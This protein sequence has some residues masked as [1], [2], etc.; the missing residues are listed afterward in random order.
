MSSIDRVVEA[1]RWSKV[2]LRG[3]KLIAARATLSMGH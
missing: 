1:S 2:T 3:A